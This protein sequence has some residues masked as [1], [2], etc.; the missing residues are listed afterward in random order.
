MSKETINIRTI[1]GE[2]NCKGDDRIIIPLSLMVRGLCQSN[3][4]AAELIDILKKKQYD[5]PPYF[6]LLVK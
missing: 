3:E 4:N 1:D 6:S 5:T 2:I